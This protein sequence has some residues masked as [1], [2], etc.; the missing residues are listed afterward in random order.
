VKNV[1]DT[2]HLQE[3]P[4]KVSDFRVELAAFH[5][6][7]FVRRSPSVIEVWVPF[8]C[9]SCEKPRRINGHFVRTGSASDEVILRHGLKPLKGEQSPL[10]GARV[11]SSGPVLCTCC[12]DK[13]LRGE[14]LET[15][16]PW[17]EKQAW[18]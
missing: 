12:R 2:G 1:Q 13:W 3:Q 18:N 15:K 5:G 4:T 11:H 8:D 6:Y 17:Q 14:A 16:G 10:L 9:E 7:T